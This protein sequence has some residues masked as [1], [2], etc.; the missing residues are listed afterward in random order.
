MMK[1][2]LSEIGLII[3]SDSGRDYRCICP[4]H[5]EKHDGDGDLSVCKTDGKWHCFSSKCSYNGT[6][7]IIGLVRAVKNCSFSEA[8]N[9]VEKH[10]FKLT[11]TYDSEVKKEAEGESLDKIWNSSRSCLAHDYLKK[12]AIEG[13]GL[14]SSLRIDEN[15]NLLIPFHDLDGKL[16]ALEFKN[17]VKRWLKVGSEIIKS[18]FFF[19]PIE[20]SKDPKIIYVTE[21]FST[22]ATVS[23]AVQDEDSIVVSVGSSTTIKAKIELLKN[24]FKGA[25]IVLCADKDYNSVHEGVTIIKPLIKASEGDLKDFNDCVSED[26]QSIEEVRNYIKA[27]LDPNFSKFGAFIEPKTKSQVSQTFR[28]QS[29]GADVG[30][31]FGEVDFKLPSGAL[32]L[33]VGPTGHGKTL[34]LINFAL[35]YLELNPLE[36]VVF[37]S[38]E[39]SDAKI[40]SYFLNTYVNRDIAKNN[41]RTIVDYLREGKVDDVF[42]DQRSFF[43]EKEAKFWKELVD[44]RRLQIVYSDCLVEGLTES[45]KFIKTY[46]GVGLVIIDYIQLL[47]TQNKAPSR[48]E[49]L[50]KIC[51]TLKNF[52][53]ESGLPILLAAQ[54]NRTVTSETELKATAIGEAGDIERIAHTII[55][56]FNRTSEGKSEIS[57]EILKC[58]VYGVGHKEIYSLNGNTGKLSKKP[59]DLSNKSNQIASD[60][61]ITRVF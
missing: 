12:K 47:N 20:S 48:Q 32:S 36:K 58:R 42:E 15:G 61:K 30:F 26:G 2:L 45:I 17:G 13:I 24:R 28:N 10:G 25:K 35:N 50:K 27:N 51:L 57:F 46:M 60:Q 37:F 4:F 41:R 53:V 34:S 52:A 40:L 1:G 33:V 43:Q 22:G 3:K 39:E 16:V 29:S 6:Q 7:D 44:S 54:F 56:I 8:K 5:E 31:K 38:Y 23:Q 49:E 59:L 21:G 9:F 11:H 14:E 19:K 55:G 18:F